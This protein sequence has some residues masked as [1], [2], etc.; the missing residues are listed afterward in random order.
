MN[1]TSESSGARTEQ[2]AKQLSSTHNITTLPC[3]ADMSTTDGP[4]SIIDFAKKSQFAN[5]RSGNLTI[6]IV[7]NN[8]GV[9]GD[10]KLKGAKAEDFIKDFDRTYLTNVR[11]PLLLMAA[12]EPYLPTDRSGRVVS[13]SSVSSSIGFEGQSIYGGTKAAVEAMTR[14]WARELRERCTVNCVNPGPVATDMYGGVGKEFAETMLHWNSI[15]PGAQV[16]EGKDSA[17]VVKMVTEGND[18]RG[19]GGRA[20]TP[21]DIAGIIGMLCTPESQFCTGSVVNS[22]G[23]MR[24][25]LA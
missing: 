25:G 1:Y 9:S 22:N 2:L 13:L 19:L 15:T 8:A 7:I 3:R 20:A 14:T 24:M 23:G 12:V 18:G 21:E 4:A 11:G 16:T 10:R 17:E 5:Q 6:H